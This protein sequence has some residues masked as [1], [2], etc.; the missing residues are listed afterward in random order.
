M[1][2]SF[3][4]LFSGQQNDN[5]SCFPTLSFRERMIGFAIC[6]ALGKFNIKKIYSLHFSG[7]LIQILS[8]GSF[9]G[10]L[11]GSP[12]KFAITYTMGNI[13]ALLR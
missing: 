7:T 10:I 4:P 1:S 2:S 6:F 9:L 5:E 13:I 8:F 3:L 11:K 12:E